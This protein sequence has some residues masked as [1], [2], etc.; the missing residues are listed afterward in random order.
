MFYDLNKC[1]GGYRF[2]AELGNFS[3]EF[4]DC[5]MSYV[6]EKEREKLF[7]EA[8]LNLVI[9][10]RDEAK[11][12]LQDSGAFMLERLMQKMTGDSWMTLAAVDYLVERKELIPVRP[13]GSV[14]TQYFVYIDGDA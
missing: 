3:D 13:K 6:Y 11:K 7:T 1:L 8:G 2:D 9:K 4:G 14:P 12:L 10:V 5:E